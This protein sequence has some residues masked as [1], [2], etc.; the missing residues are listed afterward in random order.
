MDRIT[1]STQRLSRSA[2]NDLMDMRN[3]WKLSSA[4][5]KAS[6]S[7]FFVMPTDLVAVSNNTADILYTGYILELGDI[8]LDD[9]DDEYPPLIVGSK[10]T[11]HC[12]QFAVLIEPCSAK[13]YATRPIVY[14]QTS[15][16]CVAK[17]NLDA[18]WGHYHRRAYPIKDSYYL[19][20]GWAGPAE[21]VWPQ[22]GQD[23]PSG[24][25]VQKCVVRLN[26][27]TARRVLDNCGTAVM[28][29]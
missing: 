5:G 12:R 27:Q 24:T 8:V 7:Q 25:G 13:G 6:R 28:V 15:G 4:Y 16:I 23:H 14:A 9:C 11:L 29:D 10:P 20:S 21:I 18:T 17:V 22:R 3:A 1:S 26:T 19:Q 2:W